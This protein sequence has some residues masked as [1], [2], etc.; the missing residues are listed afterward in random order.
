[1]E[2]L[3]GLPGVGDGTK[4]GEGKKNRTQHDLQEGWGLTGA[5]S[6]ARGPGG[7]SWLKGNMNAH[8]GYDESEIILQFPHG[9]VGQVSR[10]PGVQEIRVGGKDLGVYPRGKSGVWKGRR[11]LRGG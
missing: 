10:Y 8:F 6:R 2:G 9:G 3:R 1:M 4:L 5:T 11:M 7:K